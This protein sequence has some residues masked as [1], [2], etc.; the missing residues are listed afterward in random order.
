MED[1]KKLAHLIGMWRCLPWV[2]IGRRAAGEIDLELGSKIL[3]ILPNRL[4]DGVLY[5]W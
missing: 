1:L 4:D 3:D 5:L 2:R